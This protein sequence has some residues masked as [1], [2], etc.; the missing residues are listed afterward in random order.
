MSFETL[1]G[2]FDPGRPGADDGDPQQMATV[3]GGGQEERGELSV[4]G[5]CIRDILQ[6][7]G[8]LRRAIGFGQAKAACVEV[9]PFDL[10]STNLK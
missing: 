10:A 5:L 2:Q 6:Q 1:C 8:V 4:K 3:I 9:E 7:A